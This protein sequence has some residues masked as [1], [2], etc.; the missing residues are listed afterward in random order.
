VVLVLGSGVEVGSQLGQN[1]SEGIKQPTN[2]NQKSNVYHVDLIFLQMQ[3][4][5]V[6]VV[7]LCKN[8]NPAPIVVLD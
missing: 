6:I 3:N 2:E 4:S 7:I 5:A 8:N 1:I